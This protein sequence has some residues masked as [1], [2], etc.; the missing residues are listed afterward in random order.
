MMAMVSIKVLPI[1]IMEIINTLLLL[2][3]QQ[4]TGLDGVKLLMPQQAVNVTGSLMMNGQTM[5]LSLMIPILNKFTALVIAVNAAMNHAMMIMMIMIMMT[6]IITKSNLLD[7]NQYGMMNLMEIRQI[8][9]N[10]TLKQEQ[11]IGDGEMEN[12]NTILREKKMLLQKMENWLSK[13]Y[14]KIIMGITILLQ[15]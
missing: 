3:V 11:V 2:Q 12:I 6:M 4:I 10:G 1:L 7:M 14:M 15:E 8:T 9:L 5:D 13:L